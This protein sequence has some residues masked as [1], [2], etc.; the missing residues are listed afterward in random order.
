MG[1]GYDD[2]CESGPCQ[3]RR[4]TEY[5]KP[6]LGAHVCVEPFL[7]GEFIKINSNNGWVQPDMQSKLGH[8]FSHFTYHHT[9]GQKLI[10]DLQGVKRGEVYMMTDPAVHSTRRG[11]LGITDLGPEGI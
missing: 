9:N 4:R 11:T 2:I 8:A 1:R 7:Q 10:C 5:S 6:V 3:K